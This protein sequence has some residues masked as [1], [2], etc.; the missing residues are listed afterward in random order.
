MKCVFYAYPQAITEKDSLEY[1]PL[2]MACLHKCSREVVEFVAKKYPAA[3]KKGSKYG[4]APIDVARQHEDEEEEYQD[5]V[6]F[7]FKM[8]PHVRFDNDT[9]GSQEDSFQQL[10]YSNY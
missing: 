6:R 2:H 7:L 10:V 5:I 4:G 3:C 8:K 1:T 9:K